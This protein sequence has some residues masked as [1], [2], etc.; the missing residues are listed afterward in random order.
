MTK[1]SCEVKQKPS[2]VYNSETRQKTESSDIHDAKI[3][4]VICKHFHGLC[5]VFILNI[6]RG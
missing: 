3:K 1:V 6:Y 2:L 4:I 5:D